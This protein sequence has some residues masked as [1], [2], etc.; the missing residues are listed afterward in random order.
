M[1]LHRGIALISILLE[2]FF[3][4]LVKANHEKLQQ[5]SLS[6]PLQR[7]KWLKEAMKLVSKD[8]ASQTHGARGRP[9]GAAPETPEDEVGVLMR[10]VRAAEGG[11]VGAISKC[12]EQCPNIAS[13]VDNPY[14]RGLRHNGQLQRVRQR[15]VDLAKQHAI[16]ELQR[17]RDDLPDLDEIASD[18]VPRAQLGDRDPVTACDLR[19]GVATY[20]LV[21]DGLWR[22]G[23]SR[24]RD[25]PQGQQPPRHGDSTPTRVDQM[26][27]CSSRQSAWG[28]LGLIPL[29]TGLLGWCPPYAMLGITTCKKAE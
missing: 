25:Q 4:Y 13:L 28:W 11:Y 20:D 17:L 29:A 1:H 21:P 23:V 19:Q 10:F 3:V 12:L 2:F 15:A 14:D 22:A 16:A 8:I 26:R 6:R 7:L 24:A 18:A 27:G 9:T 5:Q